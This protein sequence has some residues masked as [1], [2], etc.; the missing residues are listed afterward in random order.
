MN[1][2]AMFYSD[3]INIKYDEKEKES[4][5]ILEEFHSI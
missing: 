4:P 3:I 1:N 5:T 2:N